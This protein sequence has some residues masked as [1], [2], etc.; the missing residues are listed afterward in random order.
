MIWLMRNFWELDKN[1]FSE[2]LW[3]MCQWWGW[4][5]LSCSCFSPCPSSACCR[6][7]AAAGWWSTTTSACPWC[8]ATSAGWCGTMLS[9]PSTRWVAIDRYL[10]CQDKDTI[11]CFCFMSGVVRQQSV[12]SLI[13]RGYNIPHH[14]QLYM[15]ALW[16]SLPVFPPCLALCG[17]HYQY[18]IMKILTNTPGFSGGALGDN[19]ENCWLGL[20]CSICG[21]LHHLPHISRGKPQQI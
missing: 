21:S 2:W 14:D 3:I 20:S 6:A 13:A 4:V 19:P 10:T 9:W 16:R 15:D 1:I 12:V 5:S 11:T 7:W 8:W 17:G 18:V